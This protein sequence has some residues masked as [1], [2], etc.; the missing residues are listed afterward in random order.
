[1]NMEHGT[2]VQVQQKY[3]QTNEDEKNE[4]RTVKNG[5]KQINYEYFSYCQ[6]S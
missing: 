3:K 1:M 6:H 5:L 2:C 4:R